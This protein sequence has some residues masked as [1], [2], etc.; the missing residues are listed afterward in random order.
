MLDLDSL[1]R[2]IKFQPQ[3]LNDGCFGASGSNQDSDTETSPLVPR[4][5]RDP[6][7]C[8]RKPPSFRHQNIESANGPEMVVLK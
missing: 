2:W 5:N 8:R 7:F 4:A 3:A 6:H 1:Q